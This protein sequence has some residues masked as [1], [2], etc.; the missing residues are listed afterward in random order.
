MRHELS[1]VGFSEALTPQ[2][3][4]RVLLAARRV[5][6]APLWRVCRPLDYRAIHT[7]DERPW[8]G[9]G[10]SSVDGYVRR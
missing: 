4:A 2:P 7:P 10:Y 8:E 1:Y 3:S 9:A 5:G 6:G